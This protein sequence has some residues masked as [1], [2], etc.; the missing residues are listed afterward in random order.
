MGTD[1]RRRQPNKEKETQYDS[2]RAEQSLTLAT[3]KTPANT[4]K[5]VSRKKNLTD[6][7]PLL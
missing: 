7:T 6:V 4:V 3:C 5:T 2:K 1:E